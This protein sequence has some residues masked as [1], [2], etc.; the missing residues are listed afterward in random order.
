MIGQASAVP[1]TRSR[2]LRARSPPV[3]EDLSTRTEQ[4]ASH[5]DDRLPPSSSCRPQMQHNNQMAAVRQPDRHEA[6]ESAKTTSCGAG[7]RPCQD[8]HPGP[9]HPRDI[10][11][12]IDGMPSDQHP[13]AQRQVGKPPAPAS[14]AAASRWWRRY[15]R[16]RRAPATPL[17][18]IRTLDRRPRS[19]GSELGQRGGPAM[20][21]VGRIEEVAM[22]VSEITRANAEQAQ[23]VAGVSGRSARTAARSRT[24]RWSS[25]R[26]PPPSRWAAGAGPDCTRSRCSAPP[27]RRREVGSRRPPSGGL[28]R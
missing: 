24:P 25:G 21:Q 4:T 3:A 5:A 1:P 10:I 19:A 13:V 18:R 14:R 26:L 6:A 12:V 2:R 7:S 8:Q 27:D 9:A 28:R 11:A 15:L 22:M 20:E 16:W 23:G 17:R